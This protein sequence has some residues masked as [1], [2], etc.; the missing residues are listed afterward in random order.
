MS[1]SNNWHGI[2]KI[3]EFIHFDKNGNILH[4][5]NDIYNI[6]H[7]EGESRILSAVFLGG[8]TS[9]PYI[10]SN[11]YLGLDARPSLSVSQTLADL[12]GEPSGYGYARQPVSSSTGFTLVTTSTTV[13]ARSSVVVFSATTNSWGPVTNLFLTNISNGTSGQLYSSAPLNNQVI[14][15][16]G[17]SI[18]VRFAM[19]LKN[20]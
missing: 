14:V 4:K 18:S 10:P 2:M 15:N 6:L 9:N 11:Y 5:E 20:C 12:V 3:E 19:T 13:Q 8:A 7:N 17:E 16:T 1:K